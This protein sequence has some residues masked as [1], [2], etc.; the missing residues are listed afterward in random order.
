M[1]TTSSR[2]CTGHFATSLILEDLRFSTRR[3]AARLSQAPFKPPKFRSTV[4]MKPRR[5]HQADDFSP[6]S[7][8]FGTRAFISYETDYRTFSVIPS[9]VEGSLTVFRNLPEM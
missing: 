4:K 1:P 2:S 8:A 7:W 3:R 5:L 9:E 6:L